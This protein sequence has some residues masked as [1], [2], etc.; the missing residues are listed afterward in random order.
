[1]TIKT[2]AR[3]HEIHPWL[4]GCLDRT[5]PGERSYWLDATS[6]HNHNR[7]Y[8]LQQ[9]SSTTQLRQMR[10]PRSVCLFWNYWH[11]INSKAFGPV[12]QPLLITKHHTIS[13]DSGIWQCS[14]GLSSANI[15]SCT[16]WSWECYA[17]AQTASEE[18]VS[19]HSF[20]GGELQIRCYYPIQTAYLAA[21]TGNHL[22]PPAEDQKRRECHRG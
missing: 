3:H 6:M 17:A 13:R 4:S 9:S 10:R 2:S 1:M 15:R 8:S 19:A 11:Q 18:S 12:V 14:F 7:L 22:D 21:T 20:C 16:V 5:T